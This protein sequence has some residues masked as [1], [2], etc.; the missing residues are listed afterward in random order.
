MMFSHHWKR[1]ADLAELDIATVAAM[2]ETSEPEDFDDGRQ[3]WALLRMQ[4]GRYGVLWGDDGCTCAH[5]GPFDGGGSEGEFREYETEAEARASI[6]V[7][8]IL[9]VCK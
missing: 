9:E 8:V 1:C 2:L 3:W 7:D 4:K 6:P 5:C